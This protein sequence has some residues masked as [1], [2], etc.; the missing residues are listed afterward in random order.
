MP[1]PH[2]MDDLLFSFYG[3]DLTGSTDA[4]ECLEANGIPAVLFLDP[5]TPDQVREHFPD[6]RA[7][8]VA[9][10]SRSMTPQQMDEELPAAFEALGKLRA[11]FVHYKVCST[12]DSSPTIGSIG[13]AI[14][15]GARV[16]E[17]RLVPL[18]VGAPFLRRYVAFGNLFA[19]VGDVTYRL[20]RHPTM[21]RHPTTP[22][23]EADLRL[24]LGKQTR[25]VVE[26]LDIYHLSKPEAE[27]DARFRRLLE[28]EAGIVLFDTLDAGHMRTIGRLIWGLKGEQPVFLAG[29]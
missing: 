24:H 5:P 6:A 16:F 4:M 23:D 27:L 17:S 19:R 7:V 28:G 13:H 2:P 9:G 21:S 8:G 14:D 12:F 20:D 18:A 11:P 26:L 22:M 25:R 1:V 15:I 29:S 3:D 10:L